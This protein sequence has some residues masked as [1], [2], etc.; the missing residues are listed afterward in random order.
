MK[1][2]YYDPYDYE[3]DAN[4]HPVW[5]RMRD[6]APLYWNDRYGFYALSRFDDVFAASLDEKTYSSARGTVLDLMDNPDIGGLSMIFMDPPEHT[7]M[8]KLVSHA[9]S[10]R[11]M[12][13]LEV[14]VRPSCR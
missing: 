8:R 6:E 3:I 1:E 14:E 9:F 10:P 13:A 4:P 7:E 5:K 2:L 11:R 12:A